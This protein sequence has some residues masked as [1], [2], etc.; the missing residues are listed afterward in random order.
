MASRIK[1]RRDTSANWTSVDPILANGE[2]GIEADTRRVKIGNGADKWTALDYAITGD[3]RIDGKTVNTEMGVSISQQDPETWLA[4]IKAKANWAGTNG[5]AYDSLGNLYVSGWEEFGYDGQSPNPSGNGFITKFDSQG[6]V[7]WNKYIMLDGYTN[8][9]GVVVDSD[10]N[11]A[12]VTWDWENDFFVVTKLDTD[13]T[14]VWQKTYIDDY[15]YSRGVTLAVDSNN[16]FVINGIRVDG[17]TSNHMSMFALK[18]SGFDGSV[19]WENSFGTS[20][21]NMANPCMTIDGDNNVILAGWAAPWGANKVF[22]A[23]MNAVG[24]VVWQRMIENYQDYS[25]Y[26]MEVGSI[27][28]DDMGNL[29]FVGSFEVPNLVQDLQGNNWDGQAGQ[30]I[31][32]DSSGVVQWS[33]L[34]GPGDCSDMGAQAVYK[35]GLLY[36]MFQTERKYYKKDVMINDLQGYTVQEI[37]IACY[38]ADT[39]KVLWS[40][41]FGPET[42]W[43]YSSPSAAPS[44]YQETDS[45][46]GRFI[47]VH[48]DYIAICGQAGEYSRANNN[49]TRSYGFVAQLPADG[50]LMDLEGWSLTKNKSPGRYAQIKSLD[51]AFLTATTGVTNNYTSGSN[52]YTPTDTADNVRIELLASGGNQWDFS[53]NGD[54]ELPT[55]GNIELK[56][57]HQGDITVAGYFEGTYPDGT[58]NWF[59]SVTTDAGGNKYYVGVWNE[60]ERSTAYGNRKLPYVVKVNKEGEVEWKVR[61]SNYSTSD[62]DSVRGQAN[63]VAYDPSSGNLVVICNDHGEGNSDQMLVVDLDP[64]NGKVVQSKRYRNVNND[65]DN[66]DDLDASHITIDDDGN[67]IITGTVYGTNSISFEVTNAQVASTSTVDTLMI[68]KTVFDGQEAPSSVK[69]YDWDIN[70]NDWYGLE[71]VDRY[72]SVAGT[73]REG[74]GVVVGITA[75]S[76][77]YTV[78]SLDN[79]GTNYLVGHKIKVLGTLLGGADGTNDAILTVD[80]VSGTTVTAF[81]VTGTPAGDG[82]WGSLSSLPNY[83][84]GSGFLIDVQA[85]SDTGYQIVYHN[86]G[87]T[88][89]V[90]GDVITFPGTSLGGTSPASDIAITALNVGMSMG[91]IYSGEGS[92][93]QVTT[94]G[95]NPLTYVRLKFGGADF[96]SGGPWTL[97]HY[98]Y[99]NA[100]I[101]KLTSSGIQTWTKWIDKSL[102]D[103]GVATDYDSDG[104]IYWLSSVWDEQA[105]GQGNWCYRPLVV[106]LTPMGLSQWMKTYSWDGSN[107]DTSPTGILVDSEDKVVIGQY[108][109]RNYPY[110]DY[111]PLVHRLLPNGDILWSRKWSLDGGE[112]R[113]GG[114]ALDDDDNVYVTQSRYNGQDRVQWTAKADIQN[115]RELWQQEISHENEGIDGPYT[116]DLEYTGPNIIADGTNYSVAAF[117]WDMDGNEGNALGFS[118]PSDGSAGADIAAGPFYINETFYGNEGNSAA[119]P[120]A[121]THNV[122]DWTGLQEVTGRDPIKSY[123]D[124]NPDFHFPV[125]V[126][127]EAGIKFADGTIQTT[128]ASGLP[129]VRHN[130]YGFDKKYNF[131]LSDAGK[132]LYF[133]NSG[134]RIILPP[135]SRVPFEVGTVLTVVNSSWGTIYIG[136]DPTTEWR[137]TFKV[138]QTDGWEGSTPFTWSGVECNDYGGGQIITMLKVAENYS[139][140]S[141][142]MVSCV[143]GNVN[144]WSYYI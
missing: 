2:M 96:S 124:T 119:G 74:S 17:N 67:R 34:V 59:T 143:G 24:S 64:T 13:G 111:E 91:D 120:V 102:L 80:T 7:V 106:K 65:E 22:V 108:R 140:G 16:D 129:Q 20:N 83:N 42:L 90:V 139:D 41:D 121:R 56:Q 5:I 47:A 28:S 9:G 31:K 63:S 107:T 33:R 51:Y 123:T 26:D 11:V 126:K 133:R 114:L 97:R 70:Y 100:F 93:Y 50:S 27:D 35:D 131:K 75:S 14:L 53:P 127:G 94:R 45:W 19:L 117:T 49:P 4:K 85:D 103:Y 130:T 40:N 101:T 58:F 69:N 23:K 44:N 66:N 134:S 29:Y 57:A 89:Y 37:V 72:N 62:W 138:P 76:G 43:G 21:D 60:M 136:M 86:N 128:S 141:V 10:D 109:W 132:H 18:I 92:G 137:G 88:N 78:S 39:G 116:W 125:F 15:D 79:G 99:A 84:V 38:D 87:G 32:L 110:Y 118:L 77:T 55:G 115:G 8:G 12:A 104:N 52:E 135:Y 54:L 61:L 36:A 48:G 1:L 112:G 6:S 142:W 122:A 3:L 46:Q 73:V 144:T 25:S 95:T 98:T 81:T 68:L 82:A 71:E 113:G 105:A 30:I